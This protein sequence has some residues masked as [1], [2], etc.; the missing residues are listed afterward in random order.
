MK[1]VSSSLVSYI[2]MPKACLLI[3]SFFLVHL[4]FAQADYA[5]D[6]DSFSVTLT[7]KHK[8]LFARMTRSQFE[9]QVEDLRQ[10]IKNG[11]MDRPHFMTSLMK[12]IALVGDE[13]TMLV[14]MT[15]R[16]FPLKFYVFQEGIALLKSDSS[17]QEYLLEELIAIDNLQVSEINTRFKTYIR[18][19]N[20]NYFKWFFAQDLSNPVLLA[21]L[22][23]T[24][25]MDSALFTF[26]NRS[27]AI[28]SILVKTQPATTQL[29]SSQNSQI[30]NTQNRNYWYSLDKG[31]NILYFNYQTCMEDSSLSFAA[32]NKE[33]FKAI[34]K[35]K[36]EAL[37]LDLRQNTGGNSDV[38]KPFMKE[39]K[40]S[41]LNDPHKFF[42][43]TGRQTFSSAV[44]NAVELRQTTA[45]VFIG[46][47]TG[48]NINHYGEV[49]AFSLPAT[50]LV[51]TYSTNY[52]EHWK[53]K[54]GA[55]LPD[56]PV[57]VSWT[58][59]FNEKDNCLEMV[60]RLMK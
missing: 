59:L 24:H 11:G 60:Y 36:P 13:H 19:D 33:L 23:I 5:R 15:P 39:V 42:V 16:I 7:S 3:V 41:Y 4:L 14:P 50:K 46:E 27:G 18:Q 10:R 31:R 21:G 54:E 48:G 34:K 12:I 20:E 44:L 28:H 8:N 57:P 30:R 58:E 43:L 37:V 25:S 47:A 9:E 51:V 2:A 6:L 52:F 53:G 38:L 1:R 56:Y 40:E 45:A 35:E 32:F 22:D 29:F 49:K 55:L 26:K 17:H